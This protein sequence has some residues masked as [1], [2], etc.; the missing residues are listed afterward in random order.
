MTYKDNQA[1]KVIREV[2]DSTTKI[3]TNMYTG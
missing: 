3:Y 1:Q 2:F